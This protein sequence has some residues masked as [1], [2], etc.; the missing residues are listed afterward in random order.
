MNKRIKIFQIMIIYL[1][2]EMHFAL[3]FCEL[4]V[5]NTQYALV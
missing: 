2:Y 4:F 5:Y 1:N 3:F